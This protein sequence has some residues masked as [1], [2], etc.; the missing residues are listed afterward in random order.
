MSQSWG[1]AIRRLTSEEAATYTRLG[2]TCATAKCKEPVTHITQY[3][4]VTG[5]GGRTSWSQRK[6][7][8]THGERFAAKH[9]VEIGET[10]ASEGGTAAPAGEGN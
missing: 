8:T 3:S 9:E 1:H 6:V 4:Y 2:W 10:T 7:C 5:R